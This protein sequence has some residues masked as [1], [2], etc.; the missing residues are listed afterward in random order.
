MCTRFFVAIFYGKIYT[1]LYRN[2][3]KIHKPCPFCRSTNHIFASRKTA[4]LT[5]ALA[6]YAKYHL[7]ALPKRHVIKIRELRPAEEKDIT[8][9]A[10]LGIKILNTLKIKSATVLVRD[11]GL[12]KSIAHLHYHVIPSHRIGD[13]DSNGKPR[14]VLGEKEI[15]NLVRRIEAVKQ[16]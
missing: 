10:K 8:E 2:F 15:K 13:L 16:Q 7:L 6:P 1:M 14:K 5:Y 9:L 4:Y 12:N 3:L 11:G